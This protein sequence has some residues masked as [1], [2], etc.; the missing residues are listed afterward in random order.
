[1]N[2]L[3]FFVLCVGVVAGVVAITLGKKEAP[4]EVWQVWPEKRCVTVWEYSH[5]ERLNKPCGYE[6]GKKYEII[7][8]DPSKY[9]H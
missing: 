9:G 3:V 8:V 1:M 4:I 2:P 6:Q 7:W 5:A